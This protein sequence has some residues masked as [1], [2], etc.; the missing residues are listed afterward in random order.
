VT[1][2]VEKRLDES[3]TPVRRS[4]GVD[5]YEKPFSDREEYDERRY[6]IGGLLADPLITN[7]VEV[8]ARHLE[9]QLEEV[10]RRVEYNVDLETVSSRNPDNELY[11]PTFVGGVGEKGTRRLAKH[12]GVYSNLQYYEADYIRR[13]PSS[14][15]GNTVSMDSLIENIESMVIQ[16]L[17]ALEKGKTR[18]DIHPEDM[19][20]YPKQQ[21]KWTRRGDHVSHTD[22]SKGRGG[23]AEGDKFKSDVE[24]DSSPDSSGQVAVGSFESV[25][26]R[27]RADGYWV[28]SP[29]HPE[30]VDGF[31][32]IVPFGTEQNERKYLESQHDAAPEK[33][34]IQDAYVVMQV[35]E[36]VWDSRNEFSDE[37]NT[38]DDIPT[39]IDVRS[40]TDDFEV[41]DVAPLLL[42]AAS[43]YAGTS[44]NRMPG[45]ASLNNRRNPETA[46]LRDCVTDEFAGKLSV[47]GSRKVSFTYLPGDMSRTQWIRE[48]NSLEVEY[49]RPHVPEP[50]DKTEFSGEVYVVSGVLVEPFASESIARVLAHVKTQL[51]KI[52]E[53]TE[54]NRDIE[55]LY[56][57]DGFE[58]DYQTQFEVFEEIDGIST[59]SI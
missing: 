8:A 46:Y 13:C 18:T 41:E 40:P 37:I 24:T 19:I 44:W 28:L 38:F 55:K 4:L 39:N 26:V 52:S 21:P 53:G 15:Y 10:A 5:E 50:V 59:W 3:S 12:F 54:L 34:Y 47:S 42:S 16:Y 25:K 23:D 22:S 17:D 29:L 58:S 2:G 14:A 51:P 45:G 20:E 35:L 48:T 33:M 31:E 27:T 1:E 49:K 9:D 32:M 36:F 30:D 43:A 56:L 7:S 11:S 57:G 6:L